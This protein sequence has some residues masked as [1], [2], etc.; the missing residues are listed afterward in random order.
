[1]ASKEEII[2]RQTLTKIV[3]NI[4]ENNTIGDA[5][6]I[7]GSSHRLILFNKLDSTATSKE[8]DSLTNNHN[9]AVRYYSFR[10]LVKRRDPR[11]FDVLLNH[12]SDTSYL[13]SFSGCSGME[14]TV[15]W[16]LVKLVTDSNIEPKG[17]KL[18]A[19]QARIIDSI[20]RVHKYPML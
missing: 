11:V 15:S 17:Y 5:I 18:N 12:I 13:L 1:M 16:N 19:F 9:P 2:R 10:G 20:Y 3:N 7:A 14:E 8:L 6:G 4:A